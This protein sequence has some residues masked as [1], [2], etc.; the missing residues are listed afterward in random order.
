MQDLE[1]V[2]L[3]STAQCAPCSLQMAPYALA[4]R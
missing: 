4:N 2:L 3:Y 1:E